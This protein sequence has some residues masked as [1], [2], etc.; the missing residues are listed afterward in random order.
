MKLGLGLYPRLLTPENYR[1]AHQVGVT[2]IVAH[3]PGYSQT[4]K[5]PVAPGPDGRP[6]VWTYEELRDLRAS[7]NA[8]GLDLAAI[9]NFEPIH[10]HDVLL[11]GPRRAEQ[12]AGLKTIVRNM[13]RAG[14]PVM[15]Y[16]FS[17]AGVWGRTPGA[18]ARGGAKPVGFV[19]A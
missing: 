17:I 2:H 9:E 1:F 15:G 18:W 14:I 6:P 11:D 7:L 13:G 16:N 12:M 19:E 4:V 10:W 3:L 5:R 8:E